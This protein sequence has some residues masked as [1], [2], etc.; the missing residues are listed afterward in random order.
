[1]KKNTKVGIGLTMVS[2]VSL[3]AALPVFADVKPENIESSGVVISAPTVESVISEPGTGETEKI[4]ESVSSSKSENN[5]E[6]ADKGPNLCK[7][8]YDDKTMEEKAPEAKPSDYEDE[9]IRKIAEEYAA[10]GYFLTDTKFEATHYSTGI[11]DDEYAFCNGF[12]AV[13][14]I[15]GNNSEFVAVVKATPEEFDWY[16]N[17]L[18]DTFKLIKEG[19]TTVYREKTSLQ[20][21]TIS[22][23][24]EDQVITFKASFD[25]AAKKCDG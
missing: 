10:K 23:D 18:E 7:L 14:D 22:Y 12:S 5:S 9:A 8:Y 11:G 19:K 1:M 21:I 6:N 20:T 17:S 4:I 15:S 2:V 16:V 25:D 24:R 3:V 13:D